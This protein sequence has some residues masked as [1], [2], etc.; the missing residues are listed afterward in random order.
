MSDKMTSLSK[1][2]IHFKNPNFFLNILDFHPINDIIQFT[3]LSL[4]P[5]QVKLCILPVT[6][7]TCVRQNFLPKQWL[8][9]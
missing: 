1:A 9:I 6:L 8:N 3:K 4:S 7:A 5:T 2:G